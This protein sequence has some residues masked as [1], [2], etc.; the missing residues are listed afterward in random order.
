M[1][2]YT[3]VSYSGTARIALAV[4]LLV[5]AGVVTYAGLRLPLPARL[6][7]H[8]QAAAAVAIGV[9]ILAIV[10]FLVCVTIYV[11]QARRAYS[12]L[13]APT[14]PI[15]PITYTCAALIFVVVVLTSRSHTWPVRFAGAA[16]AAMS[17]PMI[18]ELPFDLIVMAR[19][20]PPIAP[21]PA[22]YR[23]LF[24][25][26]LFLVEITTL[27][28][29]T[30]TP[31]VS[32][33]KTTLLCFSL[34]L[35]VFAIWALY[36]FGYPSSSTFFA[37]NVTSKILAF[38]TALTMFLPERSGAGQPSATARTTERLAG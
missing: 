29:L 21:D 15:T 37:L 20:Y 17:A 36:G 22:A 18:F 30:L 28:F 14:D 4:A 12:S 26:P 34:M 1:A 31:L 32:I 38:V 11:N 5:A 27:A 7:R 33:R 2:E 8:G 16:I 3:W 35:V 24:F 10:A 9:W 25:A 13:S 23:V 6:R 19:T